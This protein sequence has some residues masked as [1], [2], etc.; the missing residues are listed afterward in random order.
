MWWQRS[1]PA[2]PQ[3]HFGCP[4]R[5]PTGAVFVISLQLRQIVVYLRLHR[6]IFHNIKRVVS[7]PYARMLAIASI[8]SRN[9]ARARLL[10]WT[11]VLAGGAS[12]LM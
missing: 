10:T 1:I 6:D 7:I 8:S 5:D 11:S 2:D 12:V 3:Q 4:L 9:S